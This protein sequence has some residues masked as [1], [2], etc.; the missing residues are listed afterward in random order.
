MRRD[1]GPQGWRRMILPVVLVAAF[2]V[3]LV[4]VLLAGGVL[5]VWVPLRRTFDIA[6]VP[7]ALGIAVRAIWLAFALWGLK[8]LVG[9]V[10][11]LT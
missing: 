1:I 6:N 9:D 3:S 7:L 2:P 4:I 5:A 8:A 10:Q 11:A